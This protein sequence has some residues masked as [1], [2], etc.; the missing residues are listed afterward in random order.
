MCD[1]VIQLCLYLFCAISDIYSLF[2]RTYSMLYPRKNKTFLFPLCILGR[3]TNRNNSNSTRTVN[4]NL[5]ILYLQK[6]LI[7]SLIIPFWVPVSL[8]FFRAFLIFLSIT[9]FNQ[10]SFLWLFHSFSTFQIIR[11]QN[12]IGVQFKLY[13]NSRI[14]LSPII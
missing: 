5:S 2:G 8:N 4:S 7:F 9:L 3:K 10:S 1:L 13:L 11:F 12:L 6:M 14:R